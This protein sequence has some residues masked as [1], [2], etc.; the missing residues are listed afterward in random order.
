MAIQSAFKDLNRCLR[1][2]DRLTQGQVT[3][4]DVDSNEVS[5]EIAPNSGPYKGGRYEFK[6]STFT[7]HL[8]KMMMR[9]LTAVVVLHGI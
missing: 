1:N 5:V 3:V 8:H 6:V 4:S 9:Q 7:M 2:L